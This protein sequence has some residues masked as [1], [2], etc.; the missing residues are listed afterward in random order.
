MDNIDLK[1]HN[2]NLKCVLLGNSGVGKSSILNSYL[3]GS[4]DEVGQTT[5]GAVFW[6]IKHNFD[7]KNWNNETQNLDFVNIKLSIDV[8]DTA[9]QER[10]SGL[11]PMYTRG[12]DLA[13][14]VFDLNDKS[15][16]ERIKYWK[17]LVLK[18]SENALFVLVGNKED[19]SKVKGPK[20]GEIN[21][22]V[23]NEFE[24]DNFFYTSAK[25]GTRILD[26]FLRVFKL[27]E[28]KA[29][30]KFRNKDKIKRKVLLEIKSV[31][32]EKNNCCF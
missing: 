11:I 1:D 15:S 21:T 16:F 22:L 7:F 5:L 25:K 18:T 3:H 32:N 8:W 14:L 6:K 28:P 30:F 26:L 20:R 4:I 23:L 2:I 31:D 10:F 17:N 24:E 19:M 27:L 29:I 12:V 13:I 9:G